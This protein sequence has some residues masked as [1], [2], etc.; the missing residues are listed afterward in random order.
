MILGFEN[1]FF[2]I[3]VIYHISS[4]LTNSAQDVR[5]RIRNPE[6]SRNIVSLRKYTIIML[7]IISIFN[8]HLLKTYVKKIMSCWAKNDFSEINLAF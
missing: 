1:I 6:T 7:F 4:V 5:R 2:Q 8:K 3:G